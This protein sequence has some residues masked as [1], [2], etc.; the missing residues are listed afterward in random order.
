MN[1]FISNFIFGKIANLP[2]SGIPSFIFYMSGMWIWS[3]FSGNIKKLST[4]LSSNAALFS[5]V[6]FPRIVVPIADLMLRGISELVSLFVLAFFWVYFYIR[7]SDIAL[8]IYIL[9][10]PLII[11]AINII[12]LGLGLFISAIGFR[13]GDFP[14]ILSTALAFAMYLS[15]VVYPISKLDEGS[16]LYWIV[17]ANPMTHVIEL[18]R[19]SIFNIG[20][21][22]GWGLFYSGISTMLSLLLGLI[23][24]SIAEQNFID[25]V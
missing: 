4:I 20:T 16:F 18:F 8:N 23:F 21:I 13:Y 19:Y 1:T 25:T 12:S 14:K 15:P 11:I 9:T 24:F 6:Y 5:K 3:Y 10:L 7:G 22:N 2:T 17:M